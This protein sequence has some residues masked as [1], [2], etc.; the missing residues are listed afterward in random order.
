MKIGFGWDLHRLVEGRVLVLGGITVP[1][2]VGEA[3]HS[4]GDVLIHAVIDGL[5]GALAMG[6]IGSHFPP[7]DPQWKDVESTFLLEEVVQLIH[8]AG[9][10]P[11]NVDTT[12]VLQQ[13]KLGPYIES[14]R[15][16]LSAILHIDVAT[17]SVKAKTHEKVGPIGRG[18][19][20]EAYAAVLVEAADPSVW[21]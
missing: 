18:E 1:S 5:L 3:G 14:I 16:N 17:V 20:V 6:D 13:P 7:S 4:D 11:V 19:A 10:M 8:G 2:P 12:V 15:Q 21:V 9:Y